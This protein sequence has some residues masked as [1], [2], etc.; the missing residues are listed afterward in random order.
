MNTP[1]VLR[2]RT[3]ETSPNPPHSQYTHTSRVA[4][5]RIIRRREGTELANPFTKYGHPCLAGLCSVRRFIPPFRRIESKES[6]TQL[7]TLTN[8]LFAVFSLSEIP[9]ALPVGAASGRFLAF[10]FI[11]LL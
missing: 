11:L 8:P 3:F 1:P 10:I 4:G 5:N 6:L 7:A 9:E 2:S